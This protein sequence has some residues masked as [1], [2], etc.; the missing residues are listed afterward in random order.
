MDTF[1]RIALYASFIFSLPLEF[2]SAAVD[3]FAAG[4]T[5]KDAIGGMQWGLIISFDGIAVWSG[6]VVARKRRR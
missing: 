3:V 4:Q 5:Q 6:V 1:S 2:L